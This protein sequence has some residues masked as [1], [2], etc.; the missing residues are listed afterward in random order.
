VL[1]A[2]RLVLALM[3]HAEEWAF[4]VCTMPISRGYRFLWR[5]ARVLRF[6]I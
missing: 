1:W 3:G 2:G 4:S 5:R 6:I